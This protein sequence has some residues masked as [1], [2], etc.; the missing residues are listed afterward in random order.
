MRLGSHDVRVRVTVTFTV[1]IRFDA[2]EGLDE[3]PRHARPGA[4]EGGLPDGRDD[5]PASR[6]FWFGYLASSVGKGV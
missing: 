1:A 3:I 5:V 6:G 4:W 2:R